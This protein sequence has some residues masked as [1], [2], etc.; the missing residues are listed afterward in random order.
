MIFDL[1]TDAISDLVGLERISSLTV[2]QPALPF[3]GFTGDKALVCLTT[4][5]GTACK[6][7]LKRTRSAM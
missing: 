7:I 6:V 5:D 4:P 3:G 2:E 1:S